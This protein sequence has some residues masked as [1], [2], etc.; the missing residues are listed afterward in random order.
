MRLPRR[1]DRFVEHALLGD[2]RPRQLAF[3]R[4]LLALNSLTGLVVAWARPDLADLAL[5]F[6]CVV[7][8]FFGAPSPLAGGWVAAFAWLQPEPVRIATFT[9]A[10]LVGT[11]FASVT[12]ERYRQSRT[13]ELE[14]EKAVEL[15]RRRQRQLEP[16]GLQ[17]LLGRLEVACSMQISRQLGG[18]FLCVEPLSG[19]RISVV[20][21]DVMGKGLPAGLVA[22][23]L[24]GVCR[25]LADRG[26]EP[27]PLLTSLNRSL[28]G[29]E[30]ADPLFATAL[31]VEVDF[32]EGCWKVARAGHEL[33]VLASQ[34]IPG[35]AHLP[36]GL[37]PR[38]EFGQVRLP[39]R[40]GDC[41]V[42]VTDGVT[43]EVGPLEE[44]ALPNGTAA[45]VLAD[46]MARVGSRL[47]DDATVAVLRLLS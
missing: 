45:E 44:A 4:A 31:C 5:L 22:V 38:L 8:A 40:A 7:L 1:V 29:F 41:L 36:L 42:M 33:P 21:G 43:D 46:L 35:D 37:D 18:D 2:L 10:V 17:V 3:L 6:P 32:R 9:T 19:D 27:A 39:L 26:L 16:P 11:L 34:A 12:S 25:Q 23:Y 20:L 24:E 47:T 14:L 28:A 30:E 15:A 13:R